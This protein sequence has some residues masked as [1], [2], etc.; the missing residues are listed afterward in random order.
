MRFVTFVDNRKVALRGDMLDANWFS[1]LKPVTYRIRIASGSNLNIAIKFNFIYIPS[2]K[3][4]VFRDQISKWFYEFDF[5]KCRISLK[6]LTYSSKTVK[7]K[8]ANCFMMCMFTSLSLQLWQFWRVEST[9]ICKSG[10]TNNDWSLDVDIQ[11]KNS[12]CLCNSNNKE[13]EKLHSKW[14]YC[15]V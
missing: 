7:F 4:S 11:F 1:K 15:D 12:I 14:I 6:E 8:V 10:Q 3:R 13:I 5:Q 9:T 2:R